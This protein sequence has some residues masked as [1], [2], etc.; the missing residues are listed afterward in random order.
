MIRRFGIPE[1]VLGGSL[2]LVHRKCGKPTCRCASDER[3]PMWTLT[4][5]VGG[6]RRVEFIPED[7]VPVV[8]PLAEA[9]LTEKRSTR[10]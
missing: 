8:Q 7:L 10:F 1:D 9:A 5:S 2:S 4:Y 6:N 3:H